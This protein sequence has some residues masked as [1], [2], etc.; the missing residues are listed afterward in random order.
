MAASVSA[1][2]AAVVAAVASAFEPW[3]DDDGGIVG[4]EATKSSI[5]GTFRF[6]S[7]ERICKAVVRREVDELVA[8][9]EI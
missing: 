4:A 2:A 5:S 3:G 9:R 1:T 7:C 6:C 8:E